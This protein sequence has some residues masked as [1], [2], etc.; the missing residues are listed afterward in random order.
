ML[1]RVKMMSSGGMMGR[2]MMG[3]STIEA[4]TPSEARTI[5]RYLTDHAM[6]EATTGELAA[7]NPSDRE[8]FQA[9][10]SRCHALPS[11]S[12]HSTQDWPA[13]VA[14]MEGNMQLMNKRAIAKGEREAIARYLKEAAPKARQ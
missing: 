7:G 4:P 6:R 8:V 14:R 13:V 12:L 9:A 3:M 11:P 1:G 2:G 5:L 10:C